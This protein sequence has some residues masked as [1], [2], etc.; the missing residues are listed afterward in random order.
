MTS[1]QPGFQ[2]TVELPETLSPHN[3]NLIERR[4]SDVD[5]LLQNGENHRALSTNNIERPHISFNLTSSAQ[6]SREIIGSNIV[7]SLT[8]DSSRSM[9]IDSSQSSQS[10]A[11]ELKM[12]V[13]DSPNPNKPSKT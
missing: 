2:F 8:A 11:N 1:K 3:D 10:I 4:K 6:A 9:S 13:D 12:S 7:Y 5:F